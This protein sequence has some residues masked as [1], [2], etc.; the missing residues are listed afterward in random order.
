MSKKN[1]KAIR[2]RLNPTLVSFITIVILILAALGFQVPDFLYEW[3]PESQIGT[4]STE[5][6]TYN[7][8]EPVEHG[9]ATFTKEELKDSQ[10]GW[11]KLFPLDHLERA[12][13][14]EALITPDMIGTGTKANQSIRPPGFIS[15]LEPH[16]HA[17]GHLIGNQL[18]GTGDD[19][20]N[21][22]TL[23]QFPVNSPYMTKYENA[24]RSAAD[25]GDHIRYR[26]IPIYDEKELMPV[27]IHMEGQSTLPTGKIN[28]NV[29]IPNK[30]KEAKK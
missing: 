26:V 25:N 6:K 19:P 23:Y 11:I 2:N 12:T 28:F 27:E 20:K 14:A 15:G 17:R 24:I 18:G 22:V 1:K 8:F 16:N 3:F 4:V 29:T 30:P 5:R 7:E 9:A 13:G 21:L 10:T